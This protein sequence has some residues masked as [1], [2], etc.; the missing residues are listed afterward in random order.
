[1][2][3]AGK[4][5]AVVPDGTHLLYARVNLIPDPDG[6][7]LLIELELTEPSLFLAYAPG[8]PT[9]LAEAI[10]ARLGALPS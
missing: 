4:T 6:V 5:M 1:L 10:V 8:A 3:L 7:P 2:A 9:R